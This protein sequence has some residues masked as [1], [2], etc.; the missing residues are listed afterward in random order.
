MGLNSIQVALRSKVWHSTASIFP[1]PQLMV[2]QAGQVTSN[3]GGN[4]VQDRK[5]ASKKEAEPK[6]MKIEG[7]NQA[8]KEHSKVME[9]GVLH[10]QMRPPTLTLTQQMHRSTAITETKIKVERLKSMDQSKV[11]N[12]KNQEQI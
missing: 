5:L 11:K 9:N 10:A 3:T 6:K 8:A 1:V 7:L 4:V 12:E 2:T